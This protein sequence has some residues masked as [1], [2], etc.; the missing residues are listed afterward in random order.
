MSGGC[1]LS[2]G[3]A[4]GRRADETGG[5]VWGGGTEEVHPTPASTG[6]PGFTVC[7]CCTSPIDDQ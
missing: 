7:R 2:P 3:E 1:L 4:L 5:Q 6:Q